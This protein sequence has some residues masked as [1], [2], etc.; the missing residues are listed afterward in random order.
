MSNE[1]IKKTRIKLANLPNLQADSLDYK[2]RYR[3]ISE[4]KKLSSHWSPIFSVKPDYTFVPEDITVIHGSGIVNVAWDK[5]VF[6]IN[7]NVININPEYDVWFKW[8]KADLLGDWIYNGRTS[9]NGVV[10]RVPSTYFYQGVDQA[11]SPNR[12]TVEIYIAGQPATREYVGLRVY[13][14]AA[15]TI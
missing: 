5:V 12:L 13:N 15:I 11:S 6:K 14:P 2:V 7:D 9:S 10:T 4:D 1:I 3:I 8:S